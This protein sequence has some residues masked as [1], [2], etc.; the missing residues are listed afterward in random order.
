MR[1]RMDLKAGEVVRPVDWLAD[2]HSQRDEQRDAERVALAKPRMIRAPR[3]SHH[4]RGARQI[5]L[6]GHP[7]GYAGTDGES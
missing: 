4:A 6:L 1:Q 2:E 7:L 5:A 3:S